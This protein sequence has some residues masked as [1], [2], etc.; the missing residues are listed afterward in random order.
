MPK[1]PKRALTPG[2]IHIANVIAWATSQGIKKVRGRYFGLY[3]RMY[4]RSKE[5]PPPAEGPASDAQTEEEHE[6]TGM[7]PH[8][9]RMI[10]FQ[11]RMRANGVRGQRFRE[12]TRLMEMLLRKDE[13]AAIKSDRPPTESPTA[14]PEAGSDPG[15]DDPA[16]LPGRS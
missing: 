7:T 3:E 15:P 9:I 10:E 11:A 16:S 4:L 12:N 1:K 2:E 5:E 13:E 14:E 8:E 6:I